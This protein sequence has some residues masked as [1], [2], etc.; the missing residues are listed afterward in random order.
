MDDESTV[1]DKIEDNSIIEHNTS[2]E[3]LDKLKSYTKHSDRKKGMVHK[4]LKSCFAQ[5][6]WHHWF[7]TKHKLQWHIKGNNRWFTEYLYWK[8]KLKNY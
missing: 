6:Q 3:E 7:D 4:G 2:V 5:S 8:L 1:D